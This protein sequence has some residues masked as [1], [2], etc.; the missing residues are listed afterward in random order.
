MLC[1]YS[2]VITF[3]FVLQTN[4]CIFGLL[5]YISLSNFPAVLIIE[6]FCTHVPKNEYQCCFRP[7]H[8]RSLLSF[9]AGATYVT[10]ASAK[11]PTCVTISFSTQVSTL[12]EER[13]PPSARFN[14]R[15]VKSA[16]AC[17][18]PPKLARPLFTVS[19]SCSKKSQWMSLEPMQFANAV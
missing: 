14:L 17:C 11:S 18:R 1:V 7:H 6:T 10:A 4:H 5:M 9:S 19:G 2:T 13:R 15:S 16:R 3:N 12:S 8:S